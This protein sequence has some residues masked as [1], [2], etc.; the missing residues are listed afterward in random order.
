[1]PRE[2]LGATLGLIGLG[3]IGREIITRARPLG[4]HLLAVREHPEKGTDGADEVFGTAQ[5]D[6]V[7]AAA[8]YVLIAAPLTPTT[9]QL[10]NASRLAKLKILASK[11][12][13]CSRS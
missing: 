5:V 2:V 10:L 11:T 13:S 3:S 12:S 9:Q 4:M 1:M 6:K 7:L 8:D